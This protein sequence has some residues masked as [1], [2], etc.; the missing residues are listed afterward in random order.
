M[1][2]I[3]I[4]DFTSP[5]R[6]ERLRPFLPEGWQIAGAASRRPADQLA[7]LQGADF[8]ISG[9]MPVTAGMMAT[10][11][12]KGVHKWGVGYDNLDL[13]A[14]RAHGVRVMRT[15]GAN[16]VTVAETTLGLILALNRNILRG[17]RGL[18]RG[19]WL[20]GELSPTSVRLS[21]RT[22][23]IVGLGH[24]GKAL[25]RLLSGFGCTILYT[26]RTPLPPG[27]EA[28]LGV[29]AASLDELLAASDVVA[30]HCAL[31]D[32]TRGLIDTA[33][34]ARM[35][36]GA[37]LVNAARG[38]VVDETALAR[39]VSAG[40][41]RGAA[42]DVFATEPVEPGNPLVGND[43]IIVTPHLGALSAE[44]F[45]ASVSRMMANMQAVAEGREPPALDVLV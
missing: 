35:K 21:G 25:A 43:R 11:G 4:L 24:I 17:H 27:E 45:A 20:K 28:A 3:V 15:T 41:L 2:R 38:G 23:G 22:V 26:K 12:L 30:L 16:A 42:V 34:L 37:I 9:D 10:P 44:G 8:A 5:E 40:H 19:E 13:E 1:T 18:L 36:P 33:A 6:L 39:A 14:A 7:A 31:N 29:R 32:E